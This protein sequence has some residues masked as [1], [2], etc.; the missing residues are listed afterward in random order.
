MDSYEVG[1]D[2]LGVARKLVIYVVHLFLNL[3]FF[4]QGAQTTDDPF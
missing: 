3:F 4:Y 2:V 1:I